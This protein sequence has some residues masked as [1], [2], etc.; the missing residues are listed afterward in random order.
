MSQEEGPLVLRSQDTRGVVTLTLNRPQAFN[1]LSEATLAQ[2]QGELD[3]IAS[4]ESVRVVVI[5]A[6]GKAFCAG[7]DLKE[8]GPIRQ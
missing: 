5:A 2:L 3:A 1:A 4:D 7:H 8:C 6:E